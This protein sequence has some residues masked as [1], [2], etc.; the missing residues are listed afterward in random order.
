MLVVSELNFEPEKE[1]I[2]NGKFSYLDTDYW[3]A[4]G[5][6]CFGHKLIQNNSELKKIMISAE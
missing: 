2:I 1:F 4:K 5:E 3:S 6:E